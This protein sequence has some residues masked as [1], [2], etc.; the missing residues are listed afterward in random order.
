MQHDLLLTSASDAVDLELFLTMI[1]SWV[2]FDY[3]AVE[4]VVGW[5]SDSGAM[6]KE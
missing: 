2:D 5:L 4:E 1:A 3:G 6:S